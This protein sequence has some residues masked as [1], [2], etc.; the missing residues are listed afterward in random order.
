MGVID[1]PFPPR[2]RTRVNG[3]RKG[4]LGLWCTADKAKAIPLC[5]TGKVESEVSEGKFLIGS[6]WLLGCLSFWYLPF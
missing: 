6:L 1:C 5:C 3:S 2:Q 4:I